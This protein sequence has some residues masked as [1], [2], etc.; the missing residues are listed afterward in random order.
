MGG[1][2]APVTCCEARRVGRLRESRSLPV[3]V[4]AGWADVHVQVQYRTAPCVV[5]VAAVLCLHRVQFSIWVSL[6]RLGYTQ[7][8]AVVSGSVSVRFTWPKL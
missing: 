4:R 3:L 5:A 7:L 1:V 8:L 2:P 6:Q